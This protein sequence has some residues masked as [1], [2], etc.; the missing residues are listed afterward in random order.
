MLKPILQSKEKVGF[1]SDDS[2]TAL[3]SVNENS[4]FVGWKKLS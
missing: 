1:K 3:R 4:A 2:L